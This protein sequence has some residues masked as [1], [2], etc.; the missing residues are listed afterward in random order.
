MAI[1]RRINHETDEQRIV[2]LQKRLEALENAEDDKTPDIKVTIAGS[3]DRVWRTQTLNDGWEEVKGGL[4]YYIRDVGKGP[5]FM[6]AGPVVL[7]GMPDVGSNSIENLKSGVPPVIKRA[8]TKARGGQQ[9]RRVRVLLRAH[10][11]GAAAGTQIANELKEL[12]NVVVEA[13][14]HD[15]VPGPQPQVGAAGAAHGAHAGAMVGGAAAGL[16]GAVVGAGVGGLGGLVGSNLAAPNDDQEQDVSG[17]DESTLIYS[18]AS[19]HPAFFTP[20]KVF[21]AKRVI[22]SAQDHG[23]GIRKGF[24]FNGEKYGSSRLNSLEEGVYVDQNPDSDKI[25]TLVLVQTVVEARKEI[26]AAFYN[27]VSSTR[28]LPIIPVLTETRWEKIDIVVAE[29]FDAEPETWW[30]SVSY[31]I[32]AVVVAAVKVS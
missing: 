11:R 10:S 5:E 20:Q 18:I 29:K 14:V 27:N 24:M 21:G 25:G 16:L 32:K 1:V 4:I 23:V 26:L 9:D 12:A 22:I 28:D 13:T 3:G 2:E 7:V 6:F 15:P 8:I 31:W 30:N 17:L 19:N